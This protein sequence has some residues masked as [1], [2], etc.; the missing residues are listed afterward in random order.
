MS[1]QN[2]FSLK[3]GLF[4]LVSMIILFLWISL[5]MLIIIGKDFC[6]W[7]LFKIIIFLL[8]TS[9]IIGGICGGQAENEQTN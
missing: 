5:G 3:W 9:S 1:K 8:I 6:D 7:M 2:I 4:T